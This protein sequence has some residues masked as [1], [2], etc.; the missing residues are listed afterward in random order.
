MH[1]HSIKAKNNCLALLKWEKAGSG[2]SDSE[3]ATSTGSASQFVIFNS[4]FLIDFGYAYQGQE[5]DKETGKEAFEL[6]LWDNRIGRWL[7][8]DPYGQ[9]SS[10]YLGMGNDPVNRID[11]DGGADNPVYDSK[12]NY[13]G[14]TVEGFTGEAIIYDG[15]IDFS[16]LTKDQLI[17]NGGTYL[18]NFSF[19]NPFFRDQ[20]ESHIANFKLGDGLDIDGTISIN[21]GD[22]GDALYK[23]VVNASN[24]SVIRGVD[25]NGNSIADRYYEPTVENIRNKVNLHEVGGHIFDGITSSSKHYLVVLKQ[26]NHK[27]FHITTDRFKGKTLQTLYDTN[28]NILNDNK[29]RELYYKI[30]YP[31]WI[32]FNK[33]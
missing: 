5:K 13:K 23:A 24:L 17:N 6:R 1:L 8:T 26:I 11:S 7:T 3:V 28:P 33:N 21:S 32:D 30:G 4:S 25:R 14:N 12:G 9:Y 10:P 18:S 20:I 2:V 27:Q 19:D 22:I 15:N 29:L 16:G 31:Y